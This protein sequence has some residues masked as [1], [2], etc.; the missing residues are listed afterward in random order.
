MPRVTMLSLV[1]LG[2]VIVAV[3]AVSVSDYTGTATSVWAGAQ[4]R[5]S[6]Q[7][8]PGTPIIL[9]IHQTGSGY[10]I[11]S[12]GVW[13]G[14]DTTNGMGYQHPFAYRGTANLI[15]NQTG[16]TLCHGGSLQAGG[17]AGTSSYATFRFPSCPIFSTWQYAMI[18]GVYNGTGTV[19]MERTTP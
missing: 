12:Q 7:I 17:V 15:S 3:G 19:T 11:I 10:K 13:Y 14:D 6:V 4:T 9:N 8:I 16:Q 2:F 18:S 5:G 1:G